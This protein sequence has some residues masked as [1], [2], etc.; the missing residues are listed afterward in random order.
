MPTRVPRR[1]RTPVPRPELDLDRVVL[2]AMRRLGFDPWAA[3][4]P[5]LRVDHVGQI[6]GVKPG[7]VSEAARLGRIPMRKRLGKWVIDQ[8]EFRAWLGGIAAQAP[9]SAPAAGGLR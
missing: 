1:R 3:Y 4:P 8:A 5:V 7:S 6:L 9:V 2:D